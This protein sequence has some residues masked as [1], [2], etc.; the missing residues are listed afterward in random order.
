MID[1]DDKVVETTEYVRPHILEMTGGGRMVLRFD[2]EMYF[3]DNMC[4]SLNEES[5][6]DDYLVMQVTGEGEAPKTLPESIPPYPV[7]E[8][9]AKTVIDPNTGEIMTIEKQNEDR[10]RLREETLGIVD[11]ECLSSSKW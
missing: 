3:P 5:S 11:W 8:E 2:Q 6:K 9:Q 7:D 1:T 10:Q 4:D